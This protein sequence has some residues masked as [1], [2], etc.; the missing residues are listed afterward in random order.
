MSRSTVTHASCL[1]DSTCID[2]HLAGCPLPVAAREPLAQPVRPG[3]LVAQTLRAL[4]L[5]TSPLPFCTPPGRLPAQDLHLPLPAPHSFRSPHDATS[6]EG[7][8]G[9]IAQNHTSTG[10]PARSPRTVHLITAASWWGQRGGA[11]F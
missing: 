5:I 9:L 10:L 11:G 2:L 1:D 3:V 6:Q 7:C 8:L 4:P